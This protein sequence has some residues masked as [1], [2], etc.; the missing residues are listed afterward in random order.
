M[1]LT[2]THPES[3][4]IFLLNFRDKLMIP[5]TRF[6]NAKKNYLSGL[7]DDTI[8]MSRNFGKQIPSDA[9]SHLCVT[10]T[11]WKKKHCGQ[12]HSRIQ[13]NKKKLA[14]NER[15]SHIIAS[16]GVHR[17]LDFLEVGTKMVLVSMNRSGRNTIH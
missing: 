12:P 7:E 15:H 4:Y 3:L 11:W 14:A 16:T 1:T 17:S 10:D 8:L 13:A 2:H 5:F 9:A 6:A